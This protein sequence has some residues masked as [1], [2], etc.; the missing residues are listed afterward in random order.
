MPMCNLI[1]ITA[2]RTAAIKVIQ[3]VS[4]QINVTNKIHSCSQVYK[5]VIVTMT[6]Q[7]K[8]MKMMMNSRMTKTKRMM[9]T[10]LKMRNRYQQY[11]ILKW[12][13]YLMT[14]MSH[15]KVNKPVNVSN[16]KTY[17]KKIYISTTS[18]NIYIYLNDLAV[19]DSSQIL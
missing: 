5:T 16:I 2:A 4:T 19:N 13:C 17:Q 12:K 10:I 9:M 1:S 8:M 14:K 6:L 3:Q 11:R 18:I 15:H 7:M